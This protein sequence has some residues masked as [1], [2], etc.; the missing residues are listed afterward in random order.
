MQLMLHPRRATSSLIQKITLTVEETK[1]RESCLHAY[2]FCNLC[3]QLLFGR[4]SGGDIKDL[5]CFRMVTLYVLLFFL[6]DEKKEKNEKNQL[7]SYN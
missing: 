7:R 4:G 6:R 2:A 1:Q 5:F 3:G